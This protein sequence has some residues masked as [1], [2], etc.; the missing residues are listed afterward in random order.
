[1]SD[2]AERSA[3]PL[4]VLH[5]WYAD[6]PW[7]VRVEKV[8]A[9]LNAAGMVVHLVARNVRNR[10]PRERLDGAEVHRMKWIHTWPAVSR[11]VNV[12]SSLPAFLNPRWILHIRRAARLTR[13][14]L[15]LVRD[16]P[17]APAAIWIGRRLGIPVVLDMAENYPGFLRT[18][19]NTG[20]LR[21][22]D[23]LVRNPWLA[24][25]VERYVVRRAQAVICVIE[26]SAQRLTELGVPES[27]LAVVRNTPR[28]DAA[29]AAASRTDVSSVLTVVYLGLVERHRGVQD[30]V[31]AV[32]QGRQHGLQLRLVVIGDG[33][34]FGELQG[35]ARDLG[36]L[37][38]GVELL[39]RLE[40]RQALDLVARA[41]VGAIP[42]MPCDAWDATIPN[43]LFDYMSLG[44]PVITSNVRPVQRIVLQEACGLAY[45]WGN[46]DDL[47]SK[48]ATLRSAAERQKMGDAGRRAVHS[49]Y[50]WSNDGG[51][52]SRTLL[53]VHDSYL[54]ARAH[55]GR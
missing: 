10:P 35:L 2:S 18:L 11:L 45:Q 43:K 37:G 13:P 41:D 22:V 39:G 6:Y 26:E 49:K 15:I 5:I 17:L 33:T 50:N 46:I 30:L 21:G 31:R 55:G 53:A 1:M 14:D 44:L 52:L 23:L 48:L 27:K 28:I 54:T 51:V 47:C 7:D 16:L 4:K 19:R 34:S 20:A 12:V 9:A 25:R 36:V 8:I 3:A 42:H 38:S 24:T 32:A 29:S 40:N